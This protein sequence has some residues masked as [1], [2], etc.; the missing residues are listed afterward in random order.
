LRAQG[1][2]DAQAVGGMVSDHLDGRANRGHE[3]WLLLLFQLWDQRWLRTPQAV[4][5]LPTAAL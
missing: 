4:P 1:I 2:F 5:S 3:L